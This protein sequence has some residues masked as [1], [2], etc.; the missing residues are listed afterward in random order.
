MSSRRVGNAVEAVRVVGNVVAVANNN[1]TRVHANGFSTV[2]ESY[3]VPPARSSEYN[4]S[5]PA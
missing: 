1:E 3:F 4:V 5:T 2:T